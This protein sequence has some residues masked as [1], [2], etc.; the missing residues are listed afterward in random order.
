MCIVRDGVAAPE[1]LFRLSRSKFGSLL[2]HNTAGS[3]LV[4]KRTGYNLNCDLYDQF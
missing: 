2:D 4:T 3:I 1:K